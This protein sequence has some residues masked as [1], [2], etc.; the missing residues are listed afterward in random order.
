MIKNAKAMTNEELEQAAGGVTVYTSNG[1]YVAPDPVQAV[2]VSQPIPV[3]AVPVNGVSG[4]TTYTVKTGDTLYNIAKRFGTTVTNIM[5]LNPQIKNAN[6]INAG[7]VIRI[8]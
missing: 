6:K 7:Q 4:G 3:A 5:A 8:F 2:P 1:F